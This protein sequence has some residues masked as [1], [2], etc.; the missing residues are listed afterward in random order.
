MCTP[1]CIRD[2]CMQNGGRAAPLTQEL[3]PVC[4]ID[5][6]TA[7]IRRRVR[8]DWPACERRRDGDRRVRARGRGV[9]GDRPA[10]V[11][12]AH[13]EV[14]RQ[15]LLRPRMGRAPTAELVRQSRTP[16]NLY[17]GRLRASRPDRGLG[18][19]LRPHSCATPRPRLRHR[20]IDAARREAMPM[21][22]ERSGVFAQTVGLKHCGRPPAAVCSAAPRP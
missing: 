22:T 3:R 6:I 11:E 4:Q 9:A 8:I 2:R 12:P 17:R 16:R 1:F 14:Q 7:L 13:V 19:H 10:A 15:C 20:A 21:L 18:R 5:S